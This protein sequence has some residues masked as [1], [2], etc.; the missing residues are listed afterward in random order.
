MASTPNALLIGCSKGMALQTAKLL[1]NRGINLILVARSKQGL[2]EARDA[3]IA[4]SDISVETI[5][6][7][8]YDS[9]AVNALIEQI[10]ADKRHIGY[11]VNAV[12]YFKPVPFLE[13]TRDDYHAQYRTRLPRL[14]RQQLSQCG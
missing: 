4:A 12:G 5:S 13:H 2:S 11:L 8:L 10:E 6:V 7:D 3:I 9:L 14:W 1:A